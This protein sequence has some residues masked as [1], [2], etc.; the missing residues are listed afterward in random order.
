MKHPSVS[1]VTP[2]RTVKKS[3]LDSETNHKAG[4]PGLQPY[5]E[6]GRAKVDIIKGV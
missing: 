5:T 6:R 4:Y 2:N 3:T 1:S